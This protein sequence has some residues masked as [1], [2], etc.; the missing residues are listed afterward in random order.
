MKVC[1][2]C[3][4]QNDDNAHKCS[5]CNAADFRYICNNCKT[6]FNSG[7]CPTCGIRAGESAKTCPN[8]GVKT[9]SPF[10]PSCGASMNV[11][12]AT[13]SN[14]P[15][16]TPAPTYIVV[17]QQPTQQVQVA[18]PKKK[19]NAGMIW[20][21]IFFPFVTAWIILFSSKYESGMRIFAL[22]YSGV[23]AVGMLFSSSE[24][25]AAVFMIAPIIG[26]GIKVLIG[27]KKEQKTSQEKDL[28]HQEI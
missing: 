22:V 28:M 20:L 14:N 8:C 21:T 12:A 11:N 13:R 6:V 4:A 10:C 15:T 16:P 19:S 3:N 27:K 25:A 26:Y 7:F 24:P 23:M 18:A 1:T 9:F 2:Y 5:K 17:N